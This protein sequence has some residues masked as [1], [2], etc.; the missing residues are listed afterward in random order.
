MSRR[1]DPTIDLVRRAAPVCTE[2]GRDGRRRLAAMFVEWLMGL[3]ARLVTAAEAI[4][5]VGL[6][7]LPG[8]G[9]VSQQPSRRAGQVAEDAGWCRSHAG[10][11]PSFAC[12]MSRSAVT[13]CRNGGGIGAALTT[14]NGAGVGK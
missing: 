12:A 11:G 14:P 5:H 2:L 4:P 10:G 6:L 1:T 3:P 13:G 9:V 8:N 7:Q